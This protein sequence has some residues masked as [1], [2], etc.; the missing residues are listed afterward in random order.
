MKRVLEYTVVRSGFGNFNSLLTAPN[1]YATIVTTRSKQF[2]VNVFFPFFVLSRFT[3]NVRTGLKCTFIAAIITLLPFISLTQDLELQKFRKERESSARQKEKDVTEFL[4]LKQIPVAFNSKEGSHFLLVEIRKGKPVYR[5]TLNAN[6]AITTNVAGLRSGA[7]LGFNLQGKDMLVGVFDDG[8]VKDHIELANRVVSTEGTHERIHSTHVT[9]TLIATGI[10]PAAK[11][12]APQAKATTF[13]FWND[14]IKMAALAKPDQTSLLLSNH[15]YG[16]AT[17]WYK[18]NSEWI[19]AG[20][21]VISSVEDFRFG[22]YSD[23]AKNLDELAALAPYYSIIWAAGNDRANGGDGTRLPDCNGGTGYDCIIPDA[24]AKNIITVGAVD[25]VL[26]YNNASSV[27]M[28]NF[29]SWGPTDDGRIKPDLVGDGIDVFSLSADGL[30]SYTTASGTSMSTP[31]VTGSLLLLQ[32][33]YSKLH[34]GNFMRAATLKALAI[35]TAREAGSFPGP[36]YSYGWGLVDATAAAKLLRDEDKVQVIIDENIL[37][38]GQSFEI[39]IYP[40]ANQKITASI[41]WTDPAGLPVV[42]GLDPTNLM[43]INDLDLQIT[44]EQGNQQFPWILDPLNPAKKASRGDNFRDNVE[45]IEIDLPLEKKYK[46][47]VKHKGKLMGGKQSF[48]LIISY[49]TVNIIPKTYYWVGDSGNWLDVNHW[50]LTSG[51]LPV[52]ILPL[53]SDRIVVDENSFDAVGDNF[54]SLTQDVSALSLLWMNSKTSGIEFN[55][56]TITIGQKL[57]LG[58]DA[59]LPS[60]K[61]AFHLLNAISDNGEVFVKKAFLPGVSLMVDGQWRLI[62]EVHADELNITS[63]NFNASSAKL[64]LKRL[65]SLSNKSKEIDFKGANLTITES[66]DCNASNLKAQ[67]DNS[68]LLADG[69]VSLNWQNINYNGELILNSGTTSINGNNH[70]SKATIKNNSQWNGLIQIDELDV[71]ADAQ[72]TLGTDTELRLSPKTKLHSTIIQPI[73][74][75]SNTKAV[76]DFSE[77]YKYCFDFLRIN[78]VDI[79]N[80]SVNAGLNSV[81]TNSKNWQQ[82]KCDD[83]LFAD[84][85]VNYGCANALAEFVDLSVGSPDQWLWNFGNNITSSTQFPIH[86]FD[87]SGDYP[88]SLT[89]NKDGQSHMYLSTVTIKENTIANNSL[90]IN[91]EAIISFLM[92]DKYKWFRDGEVIVDAVQRSYSYNGKEGLYFVLVYDNQCNLSSDKVTILGVAEDKVSEIMIYPNPVFEKLTVQVPLDDE[93]QLVELLDLIG[94]IVL[95]R[96]VRGNYIQV[97]VQDLPASLYFVK[98]ISA[99]GELRSRISIMR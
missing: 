70:F 19:W 42:D 84:F 73:K 94:N 90:A 61:G 86:Q 91:S 2:R 55:D 35:H 79:K 99:K 6:A 41:A 44:D 45:K 17:G 30:N 11:G 7:G 28:S 12:M 22:F 78:N 3:L 33:L 66:S 56:K 9:G 50:S 4:K 34:G 89:V 21:P 58:S 48:S 68:I 60:G 74:I 64:S 31:N 88:V 95:S 62:G 80:A 65:N 71:Q 32:E 10:N 27:Q 97:E 16:E 39:D 15:S 52:K 1:T 81:I 43:L 46:L 20:D 83:I 96:Q 25:K 98:V 69:I 87:K 36:D 92:A 26:N 76:L 5:V 38:D 67:F 24:V 75:V 29:S 57:V 13:Y 77:H 47:S 93:I 85:K 72:L 53:S 14:E 8:L 49:K 54:I 40:K 63:G 37:V 51:G 18:N 23:R 82:K 59:F